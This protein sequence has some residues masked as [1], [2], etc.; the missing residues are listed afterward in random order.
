M[1]RPWCDE[2]HV[3]TGTVANREQP[4]FHKTTK[5]LRVPVCDRIECMKAAQRHVQLVTNEVGIYTPDK[6]KEQS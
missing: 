6:K 4:D 3:R 2:S 5:F 1:T